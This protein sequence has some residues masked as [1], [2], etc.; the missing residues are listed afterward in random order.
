VVAR[1]AE[2]RDIRIEQARELIRWLALRPMMATRKVALVDGA[3][4]LNDHGQNALLKTLEEPPGGAVLVLIAAAP[5]MLLPTVRS[6]CQRVRLDPLPCGVVERQLCARGMEP[7]EAR[8]LAAQSGGSIGRALTLA[9]EAHVQLRTRVLT[10]LPRLAARTAAELSAVAQEVGK[11]AIEPALGIVASWYRDVLGQ[12]L[13][14]QTLANPDHAAA[15]A[16]AAATHPPVRLLRQLERVCDTIR[17]VERNANRV[18]AL[19]TM[20]LALRELERGGRGEEAWTR[21]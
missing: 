7:E 12:A 2:R 16:T 14:G 9:D 6:R 3:E 15:I 20:L 19:E 1:E 21:S 17:D 11:G 13:G 10:E 5:S 4:H 8:I 18:L